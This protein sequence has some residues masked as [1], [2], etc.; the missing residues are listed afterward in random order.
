MTGIQNPGKQLFTATA[1][2]LGLS[3]ICVQ[4]RVFSLLRCSPHAISVL[5]RKLIQIGGAKSCDYRR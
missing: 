3:A 5:A 4:S 1:P 2:T